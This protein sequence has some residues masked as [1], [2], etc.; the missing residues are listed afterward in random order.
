MHWLIL[1]IGFLGPL[2]NKPGKI[3]MTWPFGFWGCFGGFF[4]FWFFNSCTIKLRCNSQTIKST[5]F[6]V[7]HSMVFSILTGLCNYRHCLLFEHFYHPQGKPVNSP[8]LFSPPFSL[9]QPPIHFIHIHT[10]VYIYLP[11]QSF[12]RTGIRHYYL[13]V[14]GFF[15]FA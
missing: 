1:T 15:H 8:A 13:F 3:L 12:C 10:D 2:A 14:S 9:V 6:K 7:Y 5:P 11:I 4:F